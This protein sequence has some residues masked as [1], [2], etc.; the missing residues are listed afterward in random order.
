MNPFIHPILTARFFI[1]LSVTCLGTAGIN[2]SERNQ[3]I[4]KEINEGAPVRDNLPQGALSFS[5]HTPHPHPPSLE[6]PDKSITG[7]V[8]M[9]GRLQLLRKST[10]RQS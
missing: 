9:L 8:W 4:N 5:T 2:A 6:A 7:Y 10:Q 3:C 1:E